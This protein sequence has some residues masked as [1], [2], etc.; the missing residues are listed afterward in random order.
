MTV[1]MHGYFRGLRVT[2]IFKTVMGNEWKMISK[3]FDAKSRRHKETQRKIGKKVPLHSSATRNHFENE[4]PARLKAIAK[5]TFPSVSF[6]ANVTGKCSSLKTYLWKEGR[7]GVVSQDRNC[8]GIW[9]TLIGCSLVS[10]LILLLFNR[11]WNDRIY[12]V[13]LML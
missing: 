6:E 12:M 9:K 8:T 7:G 3:S 4:A 13:L 1:D 10:I 5:S 11:L 2:G